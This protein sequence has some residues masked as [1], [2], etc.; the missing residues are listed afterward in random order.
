MTDSIFLQLIIHI[1]N[2]LTRFSL[3]HCYVSAVCFLH[4]YI[5]LKF[6]VLFGSQIQGGSQWGSWYLSQNLINAGKDLIHNWSENYINKSSIYYTFKR[7]TK[8]F[9]VSILSTT[10]F[11]LRVKSTNY[12]FHVSFYLSCSATNRR[13]SN[14]CVRRLFPKQPSDILP[15]QILIESYNKCV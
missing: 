7:S 9:Q 15:K 14:H 5:K 6:T 11:L 4:V 3:F 12:L 2:L 8:S 13:S 10:T 1:L